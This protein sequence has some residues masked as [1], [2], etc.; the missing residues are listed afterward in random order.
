MS[1]GKTDDFKQTDDEPTG[2]RFIKKE[3]Q[4]SRPLGAV[5]IDPVTMTVYFQKKSTLSNGHCVSCNDVNNADR[6][7]DER[8]THIKPQGP[9]GYPFGLFL[10]PKADY[11]PTTSQETVGTI[12]VGAFRIKKLPV[13]FWAHLKARFG[14]GVSMFV[15]NVEPGE[16]ERYGAA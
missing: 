10:D 14:F 3:D 1:S 5:V 12:M 6:D 4:P 9:Y 2:Y 11:K 15:K 13:G 16:R 8:Y 7:A